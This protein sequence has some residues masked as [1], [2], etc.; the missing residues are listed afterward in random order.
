MVRYASI[1]FLSGCYQE[2]ATFN[3]SDINTK[4]IT[5][6]SQAHTTATSSFQPRNFSEGEALYINYCADCHGWEGR[7]NGQAEKYLDISPPILLQHDLLAKK[8]E[9]DFVNWILTG[10]KMQVQLNKKTVP[11]NDPEIKNLLTYI[12]KLPNVDWDKIQAGQKVYD[13]L[14]MN[15]HGM[16]GHG[17]GNLASKMPSSLPDLSSS[18]YQTQHSD[19][20]LTQI[21]LKG[22][23]AMPSTKDVLNTKE[24]ESVV[25]YIRHL[26]PGY[27]SY[28]RFC[29]SCHG[30]DGTPI[31]FVLLDT[32]VE[33]I[34]FQNITIP[35]FDATYLNAHTN[36]QLIPKI[37]HM[38]KSERVTMPHF[39]DFIREKKVRRIFKYLGSLIAE[40][41]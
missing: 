40:Y 39:S 13:E 23:E 30:Q 4:S 2:S 25:S 18:S 36:E 24:I 10:K 27:E 41:P 26:S 7:G 21:I 12:N 37:Q 6:V 33:D 29:V 11:H 35:T 17:D 19:E 9:N 15:C 16:Y 1:F 32:E 5:P 22:K 34:P 8:S 28:D 31:Q 38:L 3:S 20:E 14:C